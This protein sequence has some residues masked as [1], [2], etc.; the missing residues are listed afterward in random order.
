MSKTEK[1]NL[2]HSV[3]A[4]LKS[5]AV[6]E[7][8][9][10]DYILLRYA[11]ERFL[12]RLSVSPYAERFILKGASA[13]SVWLGPIFRVTRDADL[14]CFGNSDPDFLA[15]CFRDICQQSV[16]PDGVLFDI[17]SV[18]TSEIKKEQQYKG[19]RIMFNA[20]IAQARVVL[21]FDIG[22]GDAVYPEAEFTDYPVLLEAEKPRIKVYPRYTVVA[23]KFEAMV[24]LGMKNSR[25]KDFFDIWLLTECFDFDFA[26]LKQAVERT[27]ERRK[28]QIPSSIP[29]ALTKEFTEDRMKLSQWSAFLRKIKP[30]QCPDSFEVATKRILEFLAPVFI[31]P[32]IT[33]AKWIAAQGWE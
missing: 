2:A 20:K 29:L 22:F 33:P 26:I 9:S 15:Q 25:L 6:Q 27:F 21:Q 11:L 18:Q 30:E 23:E 17:A 12:Y 31:S 13:F 5:L 4:R 32:T 24:T 1:K 19:T 14:Y 16:A 7:K 3:N 10:F 28:T 8:A